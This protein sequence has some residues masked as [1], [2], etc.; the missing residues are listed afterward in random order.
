MSEYFIAYRGGNKPESPEAGAE[1]MANWKAWAEG[2][3]DALVNPG[4]PLGKSSFVSSPACS[5]VSQSCISY[6]NNA[7]T[8]ILEASLKSQK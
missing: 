8:S 6:Q 2:L 5:D 3:G 4:T 7:R 1:Q